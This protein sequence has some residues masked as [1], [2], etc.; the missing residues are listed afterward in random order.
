MIKDISAR[1][2]KEWIDSEN[3]DLPFI[4]DVRNDD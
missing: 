1:D 2:L 3:K 4:L